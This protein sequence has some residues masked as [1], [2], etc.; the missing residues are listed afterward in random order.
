MR[1]LSRAVSGDLP[2]GER[3]EHFADLLRAEAARLR[4]GAAGLESVSADAG[5]LAMVALLDAA[6]ELE[7]AARRIES[8]G[9]RAPPS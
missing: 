8:T 3:G 4:A 7:E 1:S 9:G 6:A 2:P 5:R